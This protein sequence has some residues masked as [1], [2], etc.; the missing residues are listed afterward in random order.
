MSVL[1][2]FTLFG[3]NSDN[4][5]W[6]FRQM[7]IAPFQL[8]KVE[9]LK[10]FKLLGAGK[11]L[12]F[13]IVP[14]FGRYALF[15]VWEN[16]AFKEDFFNR[17]KLFE[18]YQDKA[19]ETWTA[20]LKPISAHG[21]WSDDNPF[22]ELDGFEPEQN[23]PVA[24]LTRASIRLNKLIP[25][26]Q[27]VPATST[28]ISKAAGLIASIG[29]GE[30]PIIRQATLSFWQNMEAAKKFAYHDKVHAEVIRKTRQQRWYKEEMFARFS[31]IDAVG[32]WNGK[33]VLNELR[34]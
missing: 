22:P 1:T 25:F 33:A 2:T 27:N 13:S 6:A 12:G 30:L 14:D 32:T 10:F 18:Q 34:T 19:F 23:Q 11:G 26:W 3:F 31:A 7:G 8:R 9:G 28:A 24:I 15:A 21:L 29:V 16:Q 20:T 4:R 17:N 5:Y